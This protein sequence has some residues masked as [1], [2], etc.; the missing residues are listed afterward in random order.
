M[1]Y[2]SHEKTCFC[3][4]VG[5]RHVVHHLY[6]SVEM[7]SNQR[8]EAGEPTPHGWIDWYRHD[9]MKRGRSHG[10]QLTSWPKTHVMYERPSINSKRAVFHH[11]YSPLAGDFQAHPAV[12]E[13]G[14][15][16]RGA[17]EHELHISRHQHQEEDRLVHRAGER[18][19]RRCRHGTAI[20]V[21]ES[22]VLFVVFVVFAVLRD[23]R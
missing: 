7:R 23:R 13:G 2:I 14:A 8:P 18:R 4:R 9:G 19:R 10:L 21:V 11:T 22:V 17:D 3:L 1:V 20:C 15:V 6:E 16:R 12:P 5:A